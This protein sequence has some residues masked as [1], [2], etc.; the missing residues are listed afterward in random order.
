MQVP[1]PE[2]YTPPHSPKETPKKT[3]D[4][5]NFLCALSEDDQN[6]AKH[7]NDMGFPL[8]KSAR[9]IQTLGG[10][11]NK[12]IVEYLLA[13]QYL[14]DAGYEEHTAAKALVLTQFDEHK[15]KKYCENLV[16]LKNFG[17][18]EDK[19]SEALIKCDIDRDKALDLLIT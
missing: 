14:E 9:A 12:K 4:T 7:L 10:Q 19:A 2:K 6:L 1:E 3:L 16:T 17:F 8:S 15:A 13:L 5:E 11:D 18:S